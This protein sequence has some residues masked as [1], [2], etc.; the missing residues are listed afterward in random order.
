MAVA[1]A[2]LSPAPPRPNEVPVARRPEGPGVIPVGP[3][4]P[5]QPVK[6]PEALAEARRR[7]ERQRAARDASPT[8]AFTTVW[9]TTDRPTPAANGEDALGDRA[10]ARTFAGDDPGA[11]FQTRPTAPAGASTPVPGTNDADRWSPPA[12]RVAPDTPYLLRAGTTV[13]HAVMRTGIHSDL[14]GAILAQVSSD[15][16]DTATGQ[17][18]LIP[19]G[20]MLVGQY[21]SNPEA[22]VER[23]LV[24]WQRLVFP[25]GAVLDLG[26]MPGADTAG[27]AGLADRVNHHYGRLFGQAALL[28][29]IGAGAAVLA[30][31]SDDAVFQAAGNPLDSAA[32]TVTE[33]NLERAPTIEIRPGMRITVLLNRDLQFEGVY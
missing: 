24:A 9:P 7:A 28:S 16:R 27:Y 2:P 33:Q 5:T 31:D 17:H 1:G 22:G 10:R 12:A 4:P 21:G 13:I 32:S 25:D 20:T 23:V 29:L 26:E 11:A 18:V 14:P 6:S 3:V 19:S 8:V 15:V 30:P